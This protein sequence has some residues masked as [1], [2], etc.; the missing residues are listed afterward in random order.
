M[1]YLDS[2]IG[3]RQEQGHYWNFELPEQRT[4]NFVQEKGGLLL[5]R[6]PAEANLQ[7]Y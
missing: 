5:A 7:A 3:A 1:S 4:L 6:S 2:H